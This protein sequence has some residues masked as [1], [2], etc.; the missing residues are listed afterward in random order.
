VRGT[1]RESGVSV[2]AGRL[3]PS[4][5]PEKDLAKQGYDPHYLGPD[6]FA[7][8]IKSEHDRRAAVARAAGL[9]TKT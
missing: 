9:S 3:I 2:S 5:P 1:L 6:Q 7:A 8:Y 4:F